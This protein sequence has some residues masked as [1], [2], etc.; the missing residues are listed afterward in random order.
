FL[1]PRPLPLQDLH[2]FPT[3]RSSDLK[4]LGEVKAKHLIWES[5]VLSAR[6]AFERGMIDEITSDLELA[7]Q[8]KVNKWLDSPLR[9]LIQTKQILT[10]MGREELTQILE[11]E[12]YGQLQMMET[13]DHSEGVRAFIEKRKPNFKGE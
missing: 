8:N 10:N 12:K 9:A 6:E 2:S 5:S 3:R 11:H 13:K 4:R 1:P 7:V